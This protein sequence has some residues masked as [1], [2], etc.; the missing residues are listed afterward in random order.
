MYQSFIEKQKNICF[1][2]NSKINLFNDLREK[3]KI[4]KIYLINDNGYINCL[5]PDQHNSMKI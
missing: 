3:N 1:I 4:L 5:I 2:I